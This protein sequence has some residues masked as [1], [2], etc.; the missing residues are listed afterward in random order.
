MCDNLKTSIFLDD[1]IAMSSIISILGVS[2]SVGCWKENYLLRNAV[3]LD[4]SRVDPG[5]LIEFFGKFD[6]DS[7]HMISQF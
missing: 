3:G 5:E 6:P 7:K 4:K 1:K 2:Y